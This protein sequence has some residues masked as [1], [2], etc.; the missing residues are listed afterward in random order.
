MKIKRRSGD[1]CVEEKKTREKRKEKKK[2]TYRWKNEREK[3]KYN[4]KKNC[5]MLPQYFHNSFTNNFK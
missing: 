3:K 5:E 4:K 1:T 2:K